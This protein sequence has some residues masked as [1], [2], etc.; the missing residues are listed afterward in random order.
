MIA[1][2]VARGREVVD[3]TPGGREIRMWLPKGERL[4]VVKRNR[5]TVVVA[6]ADGSKF[7]L[8]RTSMA[9]AGR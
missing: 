4:P 8:P 1:T 3:T 9:L 6:T 2:H 5:R 7:E